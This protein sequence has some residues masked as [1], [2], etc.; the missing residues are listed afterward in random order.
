ML[1]KALVLVLVVASA[2]SFVSC[3]KTSSHFLYAAIPATSQ[4]AVFREDPYSG[5]LTQ[6]SESPYAVGNGIQS[7]V[8]HPSGKYLYAANTGQGENDVSLFDINSDGTVNEITPRTPVGSLPY[9]LAMDPAGQ[10]LYVA[11]VKSN[12]ISV[13]AITASSGALTAVAGSPFSINLVPTNMQISPSGAFLYVSAPSQPTGVIAV[14]AVNA[15]VLSFVGSTPTADNDPSGL[16]IDPGGSYLYAANASANSISIYCIVP[17]SCITGT[18]GPA[19]TLQQVPQ[20]PLADTQQH[21]VAL[22]LDSTG[23][24]LYVANQGSNNIG[25]YTITS[26][27]GFPVEVT[28]APFASEGQPSVVALDPNGGYLYVGNQSGTA[29]IQ[30]FGIAS[31]SLN[32]IFT[33]SVGNSPTSIAI[34]K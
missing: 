9:L 19:G 14:F 7:V 20:S 24:Y 28:D 23:G 21:P 6:L 32:T 10:Y 2:A 15:G 30:A 22:T 25:T 31:G 34:L 1:Q 3:G 12:S 18:P 33:Y 8:L 26:G 27:T 5:V 4:L 16:A 17:A 13:F 11:N 29:G